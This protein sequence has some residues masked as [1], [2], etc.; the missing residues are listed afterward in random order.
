MAELWVRTEEELVQGEVAE[1]QP[2]CAGGRGVEKGDGGVRLGRY[3]GEEE[4]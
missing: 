4:L 3:G 2:D 1:E